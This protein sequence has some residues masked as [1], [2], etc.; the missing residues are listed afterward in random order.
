MIA[1]G[2]RPKTRHGQRSSHNNTVLPPYPVETYSLKFRVSENMDGNNIRP[3]IKIIR[4]MILLRQSRQRNEVLIKS[5]TL[6]P[7]L[8]GL[9]LKPS[10]HTFIAFNGY[11]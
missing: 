1:H 11:L 6:C 4:I 7:A 2:I 5:E 8:V 3:H 9:C 10:L